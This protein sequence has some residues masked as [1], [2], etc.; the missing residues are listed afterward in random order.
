M[1]KFV[2]ESVGKNRNGD[3]F[4]CGNDEHYG[5]EEPYGYGYEDMKPP[6][7]DTPLAVAA[8]F[9]NCASLTEFP[10]IPLD[11][12]GDA[13]VKMYDNIVELTSLDS[14]RREELPTANPFAL[15]YVSEE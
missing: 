8:M 15:G 1:P 2:V 3:E 14:P 10:E 12:S 5:Y 9:S 4:P 7:I 13:L 11:F 6:V